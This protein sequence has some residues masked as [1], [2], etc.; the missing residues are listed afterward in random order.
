MR[1]W[2]SGLFLCTVAI[3]VHSAKM[4]TLAGE[5]PVTVLPAYLLLFCALESRGLA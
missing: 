4:I 2:Q 3:T 1:P 5:R